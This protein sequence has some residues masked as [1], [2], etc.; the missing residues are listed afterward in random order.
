[1]FTVNGH[2]LLQFCLFFGGAYMCVDVNEMFDDHV[3]Q[4]GGGGTGVWM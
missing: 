4:G 3:C 1:M 2:M